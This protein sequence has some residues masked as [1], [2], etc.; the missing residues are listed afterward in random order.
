MTNREP[1][2]SAEKPAGMAAPTPQHQYPLPVLPT[3]VWLWM[4]LLFIP[5]VSMVRGIS[6]PVYESFIESELGILETITVLALI[7]AVVIGFRLF[8]RYGH[9][10]SLKLRIWMLVIA[11]GAA[12]FAG[13]EASW[14]QHWMGWE[15]PES[16]AAINKQNETNLH[17]TSAW[18]NQKPR[19]GLRAWVLVAG[20]LFVLYARTRIGKY[21]QARHWQ[22]WFWPTL[23]V[24]PSAV[25]I[26]LVMLFENY[27]KISGFVPD[28]FFNHRYS[29][30]EELYLSFF[31]LFYMW[32]I[33]IRIHRLP[34]EP[35]H[36][37]PRHTA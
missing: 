20:I 16:L 4:P 28:A 2:G 21:D 34:P 11:L 14:G 31:I 15:T 13:E 10:L 37:S 32:S 35:S 17:N 22:P 25:I 1:S 6:L 19:W 24:L 12:Y 30:L 9:V 8:F 23:D 3:W 7:P 18:L 29:E 27:R 5:A 36:G 26:W 33:F